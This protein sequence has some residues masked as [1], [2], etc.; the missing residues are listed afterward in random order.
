M[1]E[2]FRYQNLQKLKQDSDTLGISLPLSENIDILR[3]PIQIW[4]RTLPNRLAI[5]P[6]EGCDG[7][8]DGSPGELTFRRYFRFRRGRLRHCRIFLWGQ[9][10]AAFSAVYA[11]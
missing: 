3:Q 6:M 5:Q 4:N 11:V 2:T 7:E 9:L 8:P 10:Q 1:P